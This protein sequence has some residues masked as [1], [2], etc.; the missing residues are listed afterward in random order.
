MT[1]TVKNYKE[2]KIKG[3]NII[4]LPVNSGINEIDI[5]KY[6]LKKPCVFYVLNLYLDNKTLQKTKI[7][8]YKTPLGVFLKGEY[9]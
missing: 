9:N 7:N 6:H 4:Y 5:E 2:F 8:L 3:A 1:D